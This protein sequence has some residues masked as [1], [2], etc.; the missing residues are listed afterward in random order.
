MSLFKTRDFW[1]TKCGFNEE[2]DQ[3]SIHIANID[4]AND[5][6]GWLKTAKIYN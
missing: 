3:S 2:F 1:N 4:N 6:S 5:K